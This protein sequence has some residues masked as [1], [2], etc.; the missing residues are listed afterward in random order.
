M[1]VDRYT[2]TI[3]TLIGACLLFLCVRPY[4]D[5]SH[6][7]AQVTEHTPQEVKIVG[8]SDATKIPVEITGLVRGAIVPVRL[9][10]SANDVIVPVTLAGGKG[11]V[12]VSLQATNPAVTVP[13]GIR[14]V[15]DD[16]SNGTWTWGPIP[17]RVAH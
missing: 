10:G 5:A 4:L 13:V 2:K 14:G 8:I 16:L 3:L 6:V 12:P 7:K 1:P 15:H 9:E 17:V 11:V